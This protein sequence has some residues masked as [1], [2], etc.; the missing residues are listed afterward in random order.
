MS[1]RQRAA[2][3]SPGWSAAEPW[4]TAFDDPSP[5]SGRQSVLSKHPSPVSRA[6]K[7]LHHTPRVPLRYT[8]G[9]ML[10]PATAGSLN[11]SSQDRCLRLEGRAARL[12]NSSPGTSLPVVDRIPSQNPG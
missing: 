3:Y 9:F 7:I 12:L 6:Q 4:V 5:R 10:P 1:L 2:A 8:L 11:G